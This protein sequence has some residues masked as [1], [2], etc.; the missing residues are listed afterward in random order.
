MAGYSHAFPGLD[1]EAREEVRRRFEK[2]R[3]ASTE[4]NCDGFVEI[5]INGDSMA[6][7]ADFYPPDPGCRVLTV[8]DVAQ[9]LS[10]LDVIHGIDWDTIAIATDKCNLD[11]TELSTI[12]VATGTRPVNAKP[13]ELVPEET[14]VP[15][16]VYP[17]PL[18]DGSVDFREISPF[19][20]VRAGQCVGQYLSVREGTDGMDI[21]GRTIPCASELV[22]RL[23]AGEHTERVGDE[24]LASIDGRCE[25]ADGTF[26]VNPVL[27]VEGDVDYHTG[28]ID[29]PG[30]VYLNGQVH[31]GFR[32]HAAGS[33]FANTPLDASDIVAGA[34]LTAGYGL[35]GRKNAVVKVAGILRAKYVENCLI[36]AG[37]D[38]L[39]DRGIVRAHIYTGG[40]VATSQRG[41]ILGGLIFAQNGVQ[42]RQIGTATGPG[43]SIHCGVNYL[44]EKKLDILRSKAEDLTSKLL[45]VRRMLAHTRSRELESML[46]DLREELRE[47]N[48]MS[49]S[50]L[51]QID[52]NED[53]RIE[54]SGTVF[55]GATVEICHVSYTVDQELHGVAFFLDKSQGRISIEKLN[56][57]R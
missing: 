13:E 18:P 40:K 12:R 10:D 27:L 33:I 4:P 54:V 45:E 7:Y 44:A 51:F 37:S 26:T 21:H 38:V 56:R 35:M 15:G 3:L 9:A 32:V 11:H 22:E 8:D 34:D 48:E 50:L 30:D 49:E 43:I 1:D 25:I 55:P 53:V 29:F 6:V 36:E 52:S 23:E 47:T 57:G 2:S 41:V 39:V 28:H 19:R 20:I 17:R 14:V 24:L 42:T 46:H 31:D 16:P 5:R